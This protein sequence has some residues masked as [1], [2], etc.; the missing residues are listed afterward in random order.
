MS[1]KI[2][3]LEIIFSLAIAIIGVRL[4]YVQII[5]N[6][7]L[8]KNVTIQSSLQANLMPILGFAWVAIYREN[9]EIQRILLTLR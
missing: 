5:K 1:K 2:F 7:V 9:L 4:G 3:S 8:I 6:N